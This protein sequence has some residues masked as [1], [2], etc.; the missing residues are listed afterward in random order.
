MASD[1]FGYS[2]ALPQIFKKIGV[3]FSYSKIIL[4]R[5]NDFPHQTFHWRII[6]GTEI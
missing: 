3:D 2:A 1:V 4:E 5:F 6:D